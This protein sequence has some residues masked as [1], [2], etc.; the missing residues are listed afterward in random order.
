MDLQF[1]VNIF[2]IVGEESVLIPLFHFPL[3][4]LNK[5]KKKT[6]IKFSNLE[7]P[8]FPGGGNFL[9]GD[10]FC[11]GVFSS[12]GGGGKHIEPKRCSYQFLFIL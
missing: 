3:D 1:F 9:W 11:E 2:K 7:N 4:L 12:G 10:I 6:Q 8:I 5:T